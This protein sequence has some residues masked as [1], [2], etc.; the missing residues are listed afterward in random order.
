MELLSERLLHIREH[1]SSY[2]I[3]QKLD[4]CIEQAITM[5]SKSVPTQRH[6]DPETSWYNG[7]IESLNT[8]R[9]GVLDVFRSTHI[10]MD[11][12]TMDARYMELQSM[13]D[14]MKFV[15]PSKGGGTLRKRR[16]ELEREGLVKRV[17][18]EGTSRHG[19]PTGR[20]VCTQAGR[21][22]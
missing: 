21:E 5:E 9:R 18:S 17:D 3:S 7:T 1:I 11:E 13:S 8:L 6:T 22:L 19:Q 16:N 12:V 15:D 20:Y 10:P 4:V 2:L 14:W